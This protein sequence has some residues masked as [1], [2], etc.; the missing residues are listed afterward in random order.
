MNV[1]TGFN[2][3]HS[4]NMKK[5][6]LR[7]DILWFDGIG[8]IAAGIIVLSFNPW[9]SGFY[10]LP[11]TFI[12]FMGIVNLA[13]GSYSTPLAIR[14]RRSKRQISV[15]AAANTVWGLLC[16]SFLI[17]FMKGITIFGITHL[18]VEGVYVGGLGCLEW[19]WMEDLM[20]D[21]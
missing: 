19:Q 14:K 1:L 12:I 5:I 18:V 7:K 10:G 8:G 17:L 13:Y 15:L 9:L 20:T 3:C 11:Q 16:F 4:T 6:N 2:D 21:K